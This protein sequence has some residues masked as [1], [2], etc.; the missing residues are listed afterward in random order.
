MS[1]K[2]ENLLHGMEQLAH[3]KELTKETLVEIGPMV[4]VFR[5]EDASDHEYFM[6]LHGLF[7][8]GVSSTLEEHYDQLSS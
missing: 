8:N 1:S 2:L 6:H 7:R 4:G 3:R 5:P